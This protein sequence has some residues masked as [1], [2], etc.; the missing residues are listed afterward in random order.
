MKI[1]CTFPGRHGDLLWALPTI[2]AIAL[3]FG[4]KVD[5]QIGGEFS[6]I[7]PLLERQPYL[8]RVMADDRWSLT[9]PDEW[10]APEL[11]LL[12]HD[13]IFHCGYRGWPEKCLPYWTELGVKIAYP[14]LQ[15]MVIDYDTPWITNVEPH[16]GSTY[17]VTCGWSDE[18]FELKYGI[19]HLL[20]PRLNVDLAVI[21][22]SRWDVEGR[23]LAIFRTDWVAMARRI[24]S[25]KLFLGC[26]SAPHV[27]AVAMGKPVV[28]L[29]PAVARHNPIFYPF[30]MTGRVTVVTGNDGLP[31]HDARHTIETIERV[32]CTTS[33][34][35]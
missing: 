13:Q 31:T 26:C 4:T 9:P 23:H 6:R 7:V 35:S 12:G 28:V 22:G 20:P 30:G 14:E 34:G 18:W 29:E 33:A 5:L 2:R 24:Q 16:A 17:D 15:D 1:L 19:V 3:H 11:Q 10:R 25:S 21:E 27:L 32:L 8:D